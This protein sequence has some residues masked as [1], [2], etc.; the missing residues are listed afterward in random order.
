MKQIL[1]EEET[2]EKKIT[3]TVTNH[4]DKSNIDVKSEGLHDYEVVGVLRTYLLM[5]EKSIINKNK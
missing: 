2:M 4:K 1:N 3:I 5:K